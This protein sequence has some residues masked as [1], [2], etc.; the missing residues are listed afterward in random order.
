MSLLPASERTK[1]RLA[2]ILEERGLSFLFPLLRIQ[3]ELAKQLQAD[4]NPGQFYKWIKENLD[5]ACHTD[6]GFINALVTVLIKYI[7]QE[8][9]L[10]P[11]VAVVNPPDKSLVE[12]ERGLLEQYTPVL[13]SFLRHNQQL[14][15][16]AIH[17]LQVFCYSLGFPKGTCLCSNVL[18]RH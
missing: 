14:Q 10:V 9:T 3:A 6:P 8:S 7:T 17:S 11:G 13:R 18:A 1:E 2:E 5:P 15:L 12:K 4:P 16:M